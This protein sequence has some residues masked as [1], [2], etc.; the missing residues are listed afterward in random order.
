M[1]LNSLALKAF[2][3]TVSGLSMSIVICSVLYLFWF[4]PFDRPG[5]RIGTVKEIQTELKSQPVNAGRSESELRQAAESALSFRTWTG[6][7]IWQPLEIL[8]VTSTCLFAAYFAALY[9]RC[10][11]TGEGKPGGSLVMPT[12]VGTIIGAAVLWGSINSLVVSNGHAAEAAA[13]ANAH[14]ANQHHDAPGHEHDHD[15]AAAAHKHDWRYEQ[16]NY[17][18]LIAFLV[19]T[20]TAGLVGS[21]VPRGAS[22]SG[23]PTSMGTLQPAH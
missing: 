9:S 18:R 13:H 2:A 15:A 10:Q 23:I 11:D 5:H 4:V 14:T 6:R 21:L 3:G 8:L 19:G 1:N 7:I 17:A 16:W 22:R 20:I 12:L